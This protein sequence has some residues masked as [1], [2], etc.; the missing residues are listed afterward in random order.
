MFN[1]HIH[2]RLIV[3]GAMLAVFGLSSCID[4]DYDLDNVDM[5]I[6]SNVDLKLPACSTG[7]IQ[8]KN[9]IDLEEDGVVQL[10]A[11][12]NGGGDMY[13]VCQDGVANIDPISIDRI[14]INPDLGNFDEKIKIKS[15]FSARNEARKAESDDVE[16]EIPNIL[17]IPGLDAL[18]IKVHNYTYSYDLT[19]EEGTAKIDGVSSSVSSDIVSLEE[20][21]CTPNSMTMVL[22][23]QGVPAYF[24][25]VH[26]NDFKLS[27][28][29]E[30]EVTECS[31]NYFDDGSKTKKVDCV[32]GKIS[33]PNIIHELDKALTLKVSFDGATISKPGMGK[34][35]VFD[36]D[37]N[38]VSFGGSVSVVG[39]FSIAVEDMNLDKLATAIVQKVDVTAIF[40]SYTQH[41]P[42]NLSD[43]D[44]LI[45]EELH[46]LGDN[47][48]NEIV[49]TNVTGEFKHE[50][51]A[52]DPIKLDDLPDFLNDDD[53]VLDLDNP[54]IFISTSLDDNLNAEAKTAIT[55]IGSKDGSKIAERH[56]EEITLSGSKVFWMANRDEKV[57]V[58]EK[59]T[60]PGVNLIYT[61]LMN[62]NNTPADVT[63]LIKR[64]PDQ[65]DV[66][67]REVRLDVE[68]LDITKEYNVNVDYQVFAP[69][70]FGKEFSLVYKDSETGFDLGDDMDDLTLSS[71]AVIEMT[72]DVVSTLPLSCELEIIPL[73][74][75]EQKLDILKPITK[76]IK[77]ASTTSIKIAIEPTAGHSLTEALHSGAKQLDGIQYRAT[78]N[79]DENQTGQVLT[80]HGSLVLKNIKL[81]V[82]AG[83]EYDAN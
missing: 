60:K 51:G 83:V 70:A 66:E 31:V 68:N 20:V 76:H 12:P 82:K 42:L 48:I 19:E 63:G 67:V 49:F 54:M 56:T 11:N 7:E 46:F 35:L 18:K 16:I 37:K 74:K 2:S 5:T 30:L 13:V 79:A 47:K 4:N 50:V 71:D 3:T 26:L 61:K 8:L 53:V 43:F 15:T 40:N 75:D 52:I 55:L 72:A 33:V 80:D 41:K 38:E 6:G 17:G 21:K 28:P 34:S 62:E 27:L 73:N 78:L 23:L 77:A 9:I 81:H 22:R 58:P 24:E 65:I 25:Q 29:S 39:D 1:K 10:V 59:Y 64:I 36:A 14:S 57:F 44:G 45:P 32:N 69:L